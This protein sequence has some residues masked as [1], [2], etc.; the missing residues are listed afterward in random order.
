MFYSSEVKTMM[1]KLH[2]DNYKG[3]ELIRPLY[4]VKESAIIAWSEFNNLKFLNCA[5]KFTEKEE[6][7][8]GSGKRK[9]MKEL[10]KRLREERLNI[11]ENI[12]TALN[13][14]NLNCVLGYKKDGEYT[15]FL[16]EYDN[17]ENK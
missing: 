4:L 2:S 5:C 16:D 8:S 11:D 14:I 6:Y 17:Y 13:N 3:I 7:E 10:I 12:F 15:S 1:P 9:E